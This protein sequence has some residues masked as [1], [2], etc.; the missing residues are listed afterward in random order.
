MSSRQSKLNFLMKLLQLSI[1]K[2]KLLLSVDDTNPPKK[3]R[4]L[5]KYT[6]VETPGQRK[7]TSFVTPSTQTHVTS[8]PATGNKTQTCS[9]ASSSASNQTSNQSTTPTLDSAVSFKPSPS[10]F[11]SPQTMVPDAV[12][13]NENMNQYLVWE[14]RCYLIC[15]QG[16]G[17]CVMDT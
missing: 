3:Q 13:G 8:T 6:P 5:N 11:T 4:S 7:L 12:S 1:A 14:P 16:V 2:R 15:W 17:V 9:F 10:A